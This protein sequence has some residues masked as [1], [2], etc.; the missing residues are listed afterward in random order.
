MS[1]IAGGVSAIVLATGLVVAGCGGGSEDESLP[2]FQSAA[3]IQGAKV[4][5]DLSDDAGFYEFPFPTDVRVISNG[6]GLDLSGYPR[7]T[8]L[9]FPNLMTGYVQ[10]ASKCQGF[11][12]SSVTYF[13]FEAPIDPSNLPSLPWDAM[14][15]DS[16]VFLVDVDPSSLEIGKRFP[17]RARFYPEAGDLHPENVLV[18]TPLPGFVLRP[19][20]RYAAV[21]LRT[22]DDATGTP[23]GSPLAL[24]QLL[25][26]QSPGGAKG[27]RARQAYGALADFLQARRRSPSSIAAATVFTT[28]DPVGDTARIYDHVASLPAPALSSPPVRTREYATYYVLEAAFSAPQF[29][30]GSPPYLFGGGEIVF[31]ENGTPVAQRDEAIPVALAIPKGQMPAQGWPVV[32]YI[33]GTGGVSTQMIDRGSWPSP[34][35]P[36]REGTGPALTFAARRIATAASALPVHPQRTGLFQGMDFYNVLQPAA[37]RDNMRQAMAEQALFLRLLRELTIDPLLCPETDVSL[38][39]D[40]NIRF[41]PSYFFSMGQSL[42]SMILDLWAAFEEHLVA[43]IPSGTGG[44]FS[45]SGLEMRGIPFLDILRLIADIPA[46]EE[47]EVF[48]PILNLIMLAWGSADSVNFAQHYFLEPLSGRDPK[49]VHVSQ[50]FFDSYYPPPA[51]NAFIIAAGLQL[52]GQPFPPAGFDQVARNY[53]YDSPRCGY[54]VPCSKSTVEAMDLIGLGVADYPVTGN[55]VSNGGTHVTAVIVEAL[56]DGILD[57]HHI[58]FQLDGMKYQYGC[59]LRTLIDTG[60]PVLLAP[61]QISASCE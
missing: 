27:E 28:G 41:D 31:D 16:P 2:R 30:R 39:Q 48:H 22:L 8:S 23:L 18:L 55:L 44:H 37:L 34:D 20:T 56:E 32:I 46:D 21:V 15:D 57:G 47:I 12:L 10:L 43:I 42:G 11:G 45:I 17:L 26:R 61:D 1:R 38:A 14:A 33:H 13:R 5:F 24:Q 60:M 54:A 25:H 50:G 9:L 58:N 29:Q 7:E 6:S 40:G 35:Q 49:H 36:P 4:L 53:G 51:Q 3:E 52:A 59:F 19:N